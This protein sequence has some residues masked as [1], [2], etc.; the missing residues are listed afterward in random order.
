MQTQAL[1]GPQNQA[2]QGMPAGGKNMQ[3][4]A[5]PSTGAAGAISNPVQDLDQKQKI[6]A[7]LS[8]LAQA[9]G[10]FAQ[11]QPIRGI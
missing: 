11:R 9:G 2:S 7:A 6:A 1:L 5:Q 8:K 10:Q 3:P 4:L